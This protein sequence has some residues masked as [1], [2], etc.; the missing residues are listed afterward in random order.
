LSETIR[1]KCCCGATFERE[2]IHF[3]EIHGEP[4]PR[5]GYRYAAEEAAAKWREDHLACLAAVRA[6][7]KVGRMVEEINNWIQGRG[8]KA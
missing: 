8:G 7:V 4:D 5:T 2:C 1:L 6:S 3:L